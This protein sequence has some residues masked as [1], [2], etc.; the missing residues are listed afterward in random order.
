MLFLYQ[1]ENWCHKKKHWDVISKRLDTILNNIISE[2]KPEDQ[3]FHQGFQMT[4]P[5]GF[6]NNL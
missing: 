2:I 1:P 5:G 3:V 6:T 4:T